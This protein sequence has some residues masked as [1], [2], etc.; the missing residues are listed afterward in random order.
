MR[1][2]LCAID[3]TEVSRKAEVF[4]I[5][6]ARGLGAKLDFVHVSPVTEED[7]SSAGGLDVTILQEVEA[8][9]HEVLSHA[10]RV[11]TEHGVKD[12]RCITIGSHDIASAIVDYAETNGCD[13]IVTGSTGRIGIPRLILGSVAGD[14]IH[15]AHCP[16]TVV[17]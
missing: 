13:H 5:E 14:I 2:I 16:V 15:R 6:L 17:R 1:K 3:E 4:A 8:R 12:A 11:I 7:L 10:E 9:D